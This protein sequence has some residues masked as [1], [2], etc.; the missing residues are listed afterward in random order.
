MTDQGLLKLIPFLKDL[1][2]AEDVRD[3]RQ[4]Y[5]EYNQSLKWSVIDSAFQLKTKH[6]RKR[7][8]NLSEEEEKT[9]FA[10]KVSSPKM[11][12]SKARIKKISL[13]LGQSFLLRP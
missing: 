10:F 4:K 3:V 12:E 7:L 1:S 11:S 9:K 2:F 6:S 13:D 5:K 8:F